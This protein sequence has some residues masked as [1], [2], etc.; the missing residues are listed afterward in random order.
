MVGNKI[1]D[2]EKRQVSEAQG[3]ELAENSGA[4][5][6]ETSAK[7]GVNIKALFQKVA[8]LLP[9]IELGIGL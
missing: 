8:E 1:D 5:F 3:K 6:I 9:G 7:E 2:E 4:H